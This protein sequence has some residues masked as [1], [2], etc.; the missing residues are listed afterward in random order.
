VLWWKYYVG[1]RY[2]YFNAG[3]TLKRIAL[4]NEI[5][6]TIYSNYTATTYDEV[7]FI[8]GSGVTGATINVYIPVTENSKD[9]KVKLIE[10]S[11]TAT[12]IPTTGTIDGMTGLTLTT[13]YEGYTIKS[14][15]SNYY[16]VWY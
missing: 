5:I 16:I 1:E 14:Y 6:T 4:A 13:L 7:M 15:N 8:D 9:F 2:F 12:I 3:G 10:A 11:K